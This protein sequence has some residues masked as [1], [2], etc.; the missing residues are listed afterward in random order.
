[1]GK[2]VPRVGGGR[3]SRK[4][5]SRLVVN[6]RCFRLGWQMSKYWARG[7]ESGQEMWET[8]KRDKNSW[9]LYPG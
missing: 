9:V 5:F 8:K 6:R 3:Q 2:Q 4:D 1:M 7:R